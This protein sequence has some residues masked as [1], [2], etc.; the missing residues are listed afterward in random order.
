[1]IRL[2]LYRIMLI[3]LLSI[4]FGCTT[5]KAISVVSS[6]KP[7]IKNDQSSVIPFKLKG[8]HV[9]VV[10]VKINNSDKQYHFMVDTGALTVVTSKTA[11]ELNLPSGVEIVARDSAGGTK[12]MQLINL[13]SLQIGDMAVAECA[14]GILEFSEFGGNL[15]IPDMEI[16]GII[17]SNFLR[18]FKV[19]INYKNKKLHLDGN[20]ELTTAKEGDYKIKFSTDMKMGYAPRVECTIDK[21]IKVYGIIDTGLPFLA[22]L[23]LSL[24]EKT[25]GYRSGQMVKAKGSVWGALFKASENNILLR[26]KSMKMG[27]LVAHDIPA[28]SLPHRD[29]LI[30]KKFLSNFLVILNYPGHEMTLTPYDKLHFPTNIYSFGTIVN[31]SKDGKT[32]IAGFWEGT[33]ADKIGIEI[34]DELVM[35]NGKKIDELSPTEVQNIYYNDDIKEIDVV[36]KNK[37]GLHKTI[38]TKEMLLPPL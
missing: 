8:E 24:V 22:T 36:Y 4:V 5:M 17:G 14:A 20:T 12:P 37:T 3:C 31:K 23:P 25:D 21:N 29:I 16:D 28:I 32:L 26:V 13:E 27:A 19:I 35:I 2:F 7:I 15:K 18:H 30:G 33:T 11:M 38:A 10:P 34:G 6:G 9:I 1:M